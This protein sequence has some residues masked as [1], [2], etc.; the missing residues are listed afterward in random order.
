MENSNWDSGWDPGHVWR[1]SG[2]RWVGLG[3]GGERL[4][5]PALGWETEMM[6]GLKDDGRQ[7]KKKGDIANSDRIWR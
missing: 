3:G 6:V 1:I 5:L 7:K 2:G 4:V